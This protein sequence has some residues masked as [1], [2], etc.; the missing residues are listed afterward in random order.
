M[1][2]QTAFKWSVLSALCV[3]TLHGCGEDKVSCP[4]TI[5]PV[6]VTDLTATPESDS[7]VVLTWTAPGD[8]GD[9]GRASLYDIRY[10]AMP[11]TSS[12]WWE[13]S[14]RVADPPIP[15]FPGFPE[16]TVVGDLTP[17]TAYYFALKTADDVPNWSNL[18]NVAS[19]TTSVVPDDIPPAAVTD[20][21]AANVGATFI[22][23]IWTASGDDGHDGTASR[24][25]LRYSTSDGSG[26]WW[27]SGTRVSVPLSPKL[28]G[29]VESFTV[30]D[31]DPETHYYFALKVGDE[32]GNWSD[33]SN[34]VAPTTRSRGYPE[35]TVTSAAFGKRSWQGWSYDTEDFE[36]PAGSVHD[37]SVSGDAG[38]YGD[39][40]TGYSFGWDLEN[41]A[42]PQT[43]PQGNG[44]WTPWST[45]APTI[46]ARFTEPGDRYLY[47]K[48]R[49][50]EEGMT[51]GTIHFS[52]VTLSAT[53]YLGYIDDWR[54]YPESTAEPLDDA[55]WQSMLEGYDYGQ[56]W[57][58]SSWDE[59]DAPLGEEI[60]TLEFLSQFR[61]LVW[62][63]NDNRMIPASSKSAWFQM[64]DL[65]SSNVLALYLGSEL[66]DGEKGKLW[67]FGRGMIE[68]T[69][70][71]YADMYCEYPFAVREDAPLASCYIRSRS[72][73]F[74]FLHI[75][76]DYV[77]T[78]PG[79]GGAL[80]DLFT[81]AG[82]LLAYP[83]LNTDPLPIE[84]YTTPP[85][86]EL[87][88]SLPSRLEPDPAKYRSLSFWFSEVLEYPLPDSDT[89]LL[90]YDQSSGGE[91]GLIPL[92]KYKAKAASSKASGRYCGFRYMPQGSYDHGEIVYFFFPM[93]PIYSDQA[94]ATAKVVLSDWFG[95]PDP[96]G[97]AARR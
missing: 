3:L 1:R 11:D 56:G 35:L 85:A 12:D 66:E 64:N 48:C 46:T 93:Y 74:D 90:F 97:A 71:P 68:S 86:A 52:V 28:F 95:L 38:W 9:Q 15:K 94:R 92:Y 8:D 39:T 33:L 60:P 19:C 54:F 51:L 2:I 76:G 78:N 6:A 84:G 37:L 4:D 20:L 73:G 82:D 58:E 49:D 57:G 40:I 32:A 43:D 30:T 34:V 23:L 41:I 53:K 61:V 88:P 44:A 62:S 67:A 18:S 79:S 29:Q 13:S 22:T 45:T 83:Y 26:G 25:D 75:R 16:T 55:A 89:Q 59:W 80:V 14:L 27:D 36:V 72:F 7:S 91:T 24:Y 5:R 17:E 87:Y 65:N 69:V 96:D 63:I 21:I 47:I 50:S 77:K 31:L 10:S 81:G 42:T 70:L